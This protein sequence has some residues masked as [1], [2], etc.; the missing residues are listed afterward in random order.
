MRKQDIEKIL[1]ENRT[2]IF[3][4]SI[5][6]AFDKYEIKDNKYICFY[7]EGRLIGYVEIDKIEYIN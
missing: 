1:Y 5:L 7:V 4:N 3:I 6:I 2:S